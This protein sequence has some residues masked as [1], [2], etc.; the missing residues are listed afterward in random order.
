M[1]DI[2]L[3]E[4]DDNLRYYLCRALERAGH[5]VIAAADGLE[6]EETLSFHRFDLV[7]TD[8]VMPEKGGVE[9][10]KVARSHQPEIKVMFITGF[11]GIL[12]EESDSSFKSD[13]VLSKPFHL[14]DLIT[15]VNKVLL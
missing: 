2:L 8:V 6:A 7:L 4:D 14:R 5:N 3:A 10:A 13:K 11:S 15:E 9:L 12:M 1:A